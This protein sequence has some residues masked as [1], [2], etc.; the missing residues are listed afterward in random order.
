MKQQIPRAPSGLGLRG[1]RAWKAIHAEFEG[2]D[3]HRLQLVEELCRVLDRIGSYETILEAEG[4]ITEGRY[5]PKDHPAAIAVR[6]ERGLLVRLA[7]SLD[8]PADVGEWD[9]LTA[10]QRARKAAA[11]RW[12]R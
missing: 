11:A 2:F 12:H 9:G 6:A 10:S 3:P 5:G 4:L 7:Q 1:R 8:L